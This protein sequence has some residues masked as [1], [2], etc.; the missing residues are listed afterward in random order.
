MKQGEVCAKVDV[1]VCGG[2]GGGIKFYV[3]GNYEIHSTLFFPRFE[4]VCSQSVHE[5]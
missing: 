1:C 5:C 2:G 4:H 3:E